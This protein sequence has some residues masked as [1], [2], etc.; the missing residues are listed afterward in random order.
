MYAHNINYFSFTIIDPY[1]KI[2][3]WYENK[4]IGK[5]KSSIK[6]NT[7][8]PV[9]NEVFQFDVLGKDIN[10]MLMEVFVMDY[11]RFSRNDAMGEV[12]FGSSVEGESERK[13]WRDMILNPKHSIS[14]WHTLM[15]VT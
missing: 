15:S 6:R 3:L 10:E 9:Y 12:K 8:I 13:H 5:W 2:A 11:D 4:K 14:Q 7:L 1:I